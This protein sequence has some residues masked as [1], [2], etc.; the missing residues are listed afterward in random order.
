[1]KILFLAA[2][3]NPN[4]TSCGLLACKLVKAL[5]ENRSNEINILSFDT[6]IDTLIIDSNIRVSHLRRAELLVNVNSQINRIALKALT[7][8]KTKVEF[9]HNK[10]N[11]LVVYLTG[12]TI[13]QHLEISHWRKN[14]NK[15]LR[16]NKYDLIFCYGSGQDFNC[17]LAMTKIKTRVPWVANYHDPFPGS[18][19]PEPYRVYVPLISRQQEKA[20]LRIL[21]S[22]SYV[23]FPSKRMA[24]WQLG[25]SKWNHAKVIILPHAG[26]ELSD[27]P[28]LREDIN[29]SIDEQYFNLLHT[30][31]LLTPRDP[32]SLL[33]AFKSF[34][35]RSNERREFSRLTFIG[36]VNKE[37]HFYPEWEELKETGCFQLLQQRITYK[38]SMEL[39][40]KANVLVSLEAIAQVSPFFPGKIA[41]YVFLNRTILALS[42]KE[43]TVLDL[44]DHT[45]PYWAEVNDQKSIEEKIERL[46]VRW[47]SDKSYSYD[48][49]SLR[50]DIDAETINSIFKKILAR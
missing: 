6:E 44:L 29:V 27:L 26:I 10:L 25:Q 34:I 8:L 43:S 7:L 14:I 46:W 40:A 9:F 38:Q 12:F 4:N 18:N 15:A 45:Y 5:E 50:K 17:H 49:S 3:L 28:D 30:G 32:R 11:A 33:R 1:M 19:Y 42:P 21:K 31:T 47:K 23:S 35:S 41:D 16:E 2:K 24:D 22:A 48:Y 20:N 13:Y 37:H 36:K 39:S